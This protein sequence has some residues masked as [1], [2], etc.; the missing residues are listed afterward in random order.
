MYRAFCSCARESPPEREAE[1]DNEPARGASQKGKAA[2]YTV[3]FFGFFYSV[4]S[5]RFAP[6]KLKFKSNSRYYNSPS[7]DEIN[8]PKHFAWQRVEHAVVL[9]GWGEDDNI[10]C[11]TRVHVSEQES[12]LCAEQISE[13]TCKQ[14]A[15]CRW[16]GLTY[17]IVQNSW[18]KGW[19]EGG[20]GRYAPRG[21]DTLFMEFGSFVTDFK[22]VSQKVEYVEL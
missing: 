12:A 6:A 22:K 8:D 14:Y 18:G 9:L 7:P 17:W 5:I 11:R 3:W 10:T 1:P 19:A 16:S 2:R 21:H 20:Y 13:D 4:Y 15:Y